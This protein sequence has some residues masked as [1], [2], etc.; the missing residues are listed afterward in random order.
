MVLVHKLKCFSVDWFY[1]HP[2]KKLPDYH[3]VGLQN[4]RTQ[5]R[6]YLLKRYQ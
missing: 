4:S 3:L 2:L 1:P 6:R 5:G